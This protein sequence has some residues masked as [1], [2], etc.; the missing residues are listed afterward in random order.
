MLKHTN[1]LQR[2]IW[3]AVLK[4][5]INLLYKIR[6]RIKTII[7]NYMNQIIQTELM[8]TKLSFRIVKK[9]ARYPYSRSASAYFQ[10]KINSNKWRE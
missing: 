7:T 4:G 9:E 6:S 8:S 2:L 1:K 3:I 5:I 10:N